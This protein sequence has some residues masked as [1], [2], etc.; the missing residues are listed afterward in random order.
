MPHLQDFAWSR[1]ETFASAGWRGRVGAEWGEL[2]AVDPLAWL[3]QQ[4]RTVAWRRPS[5]TT[6]R[7]VSRRGTVYLKH[8]TLPRDRK[9]GSQ[10]W[11]RRQLKW[12][13]GFSPTFQALRAHV[14]FARH[15]LLV[16]PVLLAARRRTG[17]RAEELLVTR[18]V[19]GPNLHRAFLES[20]DEQAKRRLMEMA[21][22]RVAELHRLRFS[23]GHLLPGHLIVTADRA[24]LVYLDN[25]R[26]RRWY[27]KVPPP[28]RR[29]NLVQ[30]VH[31]LIYWFRYRWTQV[32]L[33]SYYGHYGLAAAGRRRERASVLRQARSRTR[34]ARG[35][36][37]RWVPPL[38]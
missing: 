36:S 17:F 31:H 14:Q 35:R 6:Y 23:H 34:R 28:V 24:N 7:V 29:H 3:A 26:S 19:P 1:L 10:D 25:D 20:P 18:D 30:V 5:A 9:P 32:L 27:P 21:G 12:Q 2:V 37:G 16:P 38:S 22:R 11:L 33:D 4:P 13:L 8:M 15:G